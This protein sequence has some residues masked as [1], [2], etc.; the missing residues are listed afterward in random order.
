MLEK[1]RGY[2]LPVLTLADT[3]FSQLNAN[4]KELGRLYFFFS[5]RVADA[6]GVE[7][8]YL[9]GGWELL[10]QS[11]GGFRLIGGYA[12]CDICKG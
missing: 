12:V 3:V 2:G 8:Q 4:L 11:L 7:T 6:Q 5:S 10:N 1:M 9:G